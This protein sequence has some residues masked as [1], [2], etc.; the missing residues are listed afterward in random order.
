MRDIVNIKS[1]KLDRMLVVKFGSKMQTIK[2]FMFQMVLFAFS[3]MLF[4]TTILS[5]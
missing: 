2:S 1:K 4:F 3:I 5:K